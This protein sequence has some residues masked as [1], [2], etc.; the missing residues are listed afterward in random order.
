MVPDCDCPIML[1]GGLAR[2]KGSAFLDLGGFGEAHVIDTLEQIVGEAELEFERFGAEEGR[3]GVGLL[4]C[5]GDGDL[6]CR[7][8]EICWWFF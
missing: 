3:V 7:L 6:E 1:M 2:S 4:V 5:E 8:D